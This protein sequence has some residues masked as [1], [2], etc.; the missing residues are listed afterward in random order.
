M[1]NIYF[2]TYNI[3]CLLYLT[4]ISLTKAFIT[5][6]NCMRHKYYLFINRQITFIYIFNYLQ[7]FQV[8]I[9][10]KNWLIQKKAEKHYYSTIKKKRSSLIVDIP[11]SWWDFFS[12]GPLK[13]R[14]LN[15]KHKGQWAIRGL[16]P[17]FR[18]ESPPKQKKNMMVAPQIRGA[19][20]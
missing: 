7:C 3:S 8:F 17:L 1:Y 14:S 5:T 12:R 10:I 18:H 9:K 16:E 13:K 6:E 4:L 11:K 15:K 20:R 2:F 19:P